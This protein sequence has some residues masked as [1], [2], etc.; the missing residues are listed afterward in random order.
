[1]TNPQVQ[2]WLDQEDQLVSQ[3]IRK[4]GWFIQIVGGSADARPPIFAYGSRQRS[5]VTKPVS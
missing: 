1:M 4:H 5:G 3:T 2:A